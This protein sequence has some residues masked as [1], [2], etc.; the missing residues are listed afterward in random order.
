MMN[1][2]TYIIAG[3]WLFLFTGCKA[4]KNNST[5]QESENNKDNFRVER[6]FDKTSET[7]Y[8]LT[9]IKHKDKSGKLV[10]LHH[11]HAETERGETVR[12]FA[13]KKNSP[14]AFNASTQRVG[15]SSVRIP[16]GVQ[17]VD[18][19]I[20]Y[21]ATSTAYILGIK[22]NNELLAYKPG[23]KAQD[24]LKD[25]SNN[26]LTAFGPLVENYQKASEEALKVRK[27]Y[28]DKHPRQVIAQLKNMDIVFLSC[29]GRGYDGEGMTSED[30][31]RILTELK[32]VRFAYMLDGGGSTSI[33]VNGELITK[34]IDRKGTEERLRPDFLYIR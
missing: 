9:Y 34:K 1:R 13:Q 10:K 5:Q 2:R 4:L 15:G 24:I 3:L 25:G 22:D 28:N 30:V 7:Y 14:L 21:E 26:A 8:F 23:T 11:A 12:E 18:G 29:G 6:M 27:M 31:I 20:I 19:K 17:I 33:V 32:E 16:S